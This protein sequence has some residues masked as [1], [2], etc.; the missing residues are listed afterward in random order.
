[1]YCTNFTY[2][3]ESADD[4]G[5]MICSFDGTKNETVTAGSKV[6]MSTVKVP[7]RNKWM[8]TNAVY[9]EQLTFSFS[10]CKNTCQSYDESIEFSAEDQARIMRWLCRKNFYYINFY[11]D[12][13]EDIY[14]NAIL[15][16]ERRVLNGM[17]IG[18]DIT[19]TCDAPWGYSNLRVATV[20]SEKPRVYNTSDEIGSI[21]PDEIKIK[22]KTNGNVVIKNNLD[23]YDLDNNETTEIAS[24]EA[25]EIITL[26]DMLE[27]K[28]NKAHE[29]LYD[30]FNWQFIKL[31]NQYSAGMNEFTL[32]NCE[33]ELTWREIRK[34]VV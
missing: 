34:A 12:G 27:I 3:G 1:M 15:S 13:Y 5:V 19:A 7:N 9:N 23:I 33:L 4:H 25:G 10:I 17:I 14:Y 29:G 24:C 30:D 21:I 26:T 20:T 32:T 11:Q 31:Y 6:E 2:D 22:V 8:R 18:Y 28:S 16:V